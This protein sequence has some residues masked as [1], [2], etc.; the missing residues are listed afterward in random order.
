MSVQKTR[1]MKQKRETQPNLS[2]VTIRGN[3]DDQKFPLL[4]TISDVVKSSAISNHMETRDRERSFGHRTLYFHSTPRRR[5]QHASGSFNF[6]SRSTG[7]S[8]AG[9]IKAG[10][11]SEMCQS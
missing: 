10:D 2:P 5:G 11:N 7:A 9:E 3:V 8:P 4:P 1:R 6:M